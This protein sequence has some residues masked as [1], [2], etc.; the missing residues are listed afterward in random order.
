MVDGPRGAENDIEMWIGRWNNQKCGGGE[1][2]TLISGRQT[3]APD[4]LFP[5]LSPK[6]QIFSV[7]IDYISQSTT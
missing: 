5:L 1:L 3:D 6:L 4:K 7:I 2:Q